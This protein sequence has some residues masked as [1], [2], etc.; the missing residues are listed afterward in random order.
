[1]KRILSKVAI[2]TVI[3]G[4]SISVL[5]DSAGG[6]TSPTSGKASASFQWLGAVPV[7]PISGK[8]EIYNKGTVDFNNASLSFQESESEP[9][10]YE[11]S[12]SSVVSFGVRDVDSKKD[13][14]SFDYEVQR[15][16]Y[17]AG[18]FARPVNRTNPEFVVKAEDTVLVEGTP[19][20][21][22]V[23]KAV[24]L[25]VATPNPTDVVRQGSDVIV[26]NAIIISNAK[27]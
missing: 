17:S 7:K 20:S 26:T 9:G 4:V 23:G 24:N 8:F 14:A 19:V 13:A 11:I 2:A 18:G 15:V 27:I 5:A 22:K 6:A 3:T 12:G 10:K 16:R 21:H 1:M 25:T